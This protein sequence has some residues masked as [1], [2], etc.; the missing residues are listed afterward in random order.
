MLSFTRPGNSNACPKPHDL[1]VVFRAKRKKT[2][3][4]RV[5]RNGK[6]SKFYTRTLEKDG[7]Y[8]Q[9]R[10]DKSYKLD[11]GSTTLPDPGARRPQERGHRQDRHLS[12]LQGHLDL[13]E[14]HPWQ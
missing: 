14:I 1:K 12:A 6:L 11:P 13:H 7:E 8:Y 4:F 9:A 3:K 10:F 2:I 5:R